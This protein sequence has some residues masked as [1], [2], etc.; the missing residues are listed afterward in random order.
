[1]DAPAQRNLP[2]VADRLVRGD[3]HLHGWVYKI[4][5]GD[6]FAYDL[7]SE[8]FVSLAQYKYRRSETKIRHRT[9]NA[10]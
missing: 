9:T 7:L 2:A 1:M 8:E 3:V 5:T 10:I 6:V 4:E